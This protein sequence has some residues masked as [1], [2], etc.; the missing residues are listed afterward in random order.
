[1]GR[2]DRN[3]LGSGRDWLKTLPGVGGIEQNSFRSER[4]WS[5]LLCQC[6]GCVRIPYGVDEIGLNPL[7]SGNDW[8]DFLKK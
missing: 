4:D 6:A 5:T 1:M 7:G 8:S 3:S 2:I